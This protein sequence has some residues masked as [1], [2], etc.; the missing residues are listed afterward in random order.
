MLMR[1]SVLLSV[2]LLG[3]FS[4]LAH[5]GDCTKTVMGGG[6]SMEAQAGVASHMRSQSAPPVGQEK[7]QATAA[8][9]PAAINANSKLGANAPVNA[10]KPKL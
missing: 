8:A 7:V 10:A 2:M 3:S 9:V 1:I 4:G 6:C 5:A